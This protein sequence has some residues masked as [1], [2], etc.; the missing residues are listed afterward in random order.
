MIL[1]ITDFVASTLWRNRANRKQA[2]RD[3]DLRARGVLAPAVVV[4]ARTHMSRSNVDGRYLRIDYTADV[5]PNGGAP[6]RAEFHHWS[7]RRGHT[8][9][10]GELHGEAGKHIWV[11]F[12]PAN[13]ADMIFEYDEEQRVARAREAD[14]DARRLAFNAAAEPLEVLREHG[15]P[16]HGVI[17]QADDLQLPYPARNSTAMLLHLEVTPQGG[18]PYQASIPALIGVPALAKYSAGRQVHVRIDPRDPSR[19]VLDSAR[20]RSLPN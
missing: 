16:A 2:E 3:A 11:T 7:E 13:P 4:S 5:Y 19:F 12:D 1:E 18:A 6:F 15:V 9:T 14:L 10:M 20:N 8:A 17:V